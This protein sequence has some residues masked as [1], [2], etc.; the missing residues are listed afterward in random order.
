MT[1]F[2][3]KITILPKIKKS[4]LKINNFNKFWEI[5]IGDFLFAL[6]ALFR[7]AVSRPKRLLKGGVEH[8]G[9]ACGRHAIRVSQIH[10]PSAVNPSSA[11]IFTSSV[12]PTPAI[13]SMSPEIAA[14]APAVNNSL[15]ESGRSPRPPAMRIFASG[16]RKR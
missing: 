5:A 7:E 4:C 15:P 1:I 9:T 12:S 14:F 6:F 16:I 11:I 10:I 2:D 8:D 13:V 3:E